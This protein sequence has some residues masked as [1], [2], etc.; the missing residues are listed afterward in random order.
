LGG[1]VVL[2]VKKVKTPARSSKNIQKKGSEN[3]RE[4]KRK[5]SK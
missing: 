1:V 5:K 4:N 2:D 3:E